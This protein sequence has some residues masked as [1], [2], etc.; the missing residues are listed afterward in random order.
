MDCWGGFSRQAFRNWGPM[1]RLA[2]PDVIMV[3]SDS[4]A[5]QIVAF[6]SSFLSTNELAAQSI[7]STLASLAYRL[8]FPFSM[9]ASARGSNLMGAGMVKSARTSSEVALAQ[10]TGLGLFAGLVLFLG[11]DRLPYLFTDDVEVAHF[12]TKCLPLI[13]A[14]Q[15][16]DAVVTVGNG[17][18]RAIGAQ[19][20]GGYSMSF[21]YYTVR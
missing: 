6:L 12:A 15:V 13:G 10:C 21:A 1:I 5:F 16:I 17:T 3:I 18:L 20:V 19:Y 2:V 4:L 11:R 7:L 9:A 14:F 8:P